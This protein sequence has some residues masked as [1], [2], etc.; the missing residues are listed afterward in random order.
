M[1]RSAAIRRAAT[2]A[3]ALLAAL[4]LAGCATP[5]VASLQQH[6][7]ETLPASAAIGNVP[8]Y[9]QEEHQ[10]GP[11]AL[12]MAASAAGVPLR[13]EQLTDQVYLPERKGSLQLEMFAAG[14]RYGL[15]AY[16]LKPALE[17]LLQ[18]VAA[19]NPVIVLQ[20]VS[21]SFAP[22]WHY[23]VVTGYDRSGNT[24]TLNSG[25][26]RNMELS[27]F[28][29]ERIWKRADNWAMVLLAPTRLPATAEPVAYASAAAALERNAPTA[30][31]AAYA[32][33][34]KKW[35]TDPIL[36]LG[37]GNTAY[38]LGELDAATQAYRQL[39]QLKPEFADAWNNLAQTLLDK[40]R[41]EEA[42]A[43]IDHAIALGGERLPRYRELQ[44]EIQSSL[45]A[46]R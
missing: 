2:L 21:F 12:A 8:F 23:A 11:A 10:C 26:T 24:L 18:E 43:A 19:G 38:S 27:L 5:E 42:S 32:A 28:V 25:R 3:T 6:W 40:G 37:A 9:P 13:P 31:Q 33:G 39:T 46:A 45:Q 16:Q 7:P 14:R 41:T 30:A 36:M 34:L 4:L 35:P 20:N 29:F 15:L 17:T 44:N 22:I 1:I